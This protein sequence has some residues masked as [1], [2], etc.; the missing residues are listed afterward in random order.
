M[1]QNDAPLGCAQGPEHDRFVDASPMGRDQSPRY[2]QRAHDESH[3]A[4][5]SHRAHDLVE[6]TV[7]RVQG[8]TNADGRDDRVGRAD[9]LHDAGFRFRVRLKSVRPGQCRE[10]SEWGLAQ[11][12]RGKDHDEVD[13]DRAPS[14]FAEVR[15]FGGEAA[16]KNA[17]G[18]R[19]P[20]FEA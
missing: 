6:N 18:D 16:A 9:R 2:D 17:D 14:H 1:R 4:S 13:I 3:A 19:I 20:D 11:R 10:I 8:V 15:D 12:V 7:Y 5:N